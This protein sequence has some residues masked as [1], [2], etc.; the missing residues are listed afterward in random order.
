MSLLSS[1]A[2]TSSNG[3]VKHFLP[4]LA[5]TLWCVACATVAQ[6]GGT[7]YSTFC[8]HP[9]AAAAPLHFPP[10]QGAYQLQLC[11]ARR[12]TSPRFPISPALL[13]Q[14]HAQPRPR[15]RVLALSDSGHLHGLTWPDGVY[16]VGV[17]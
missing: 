13:H 16:K 5:P 3:T 9:G 12:A 17:R 6:P 11:R 10:P 1:Y 7:H 4:L 2:V 14:H 15:I 8:P